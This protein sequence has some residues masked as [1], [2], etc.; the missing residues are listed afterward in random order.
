MLETLLQY[1]QSSPAALWGLF[2]IL[3]LCGLGVPVPEDII[4]ITAGIWATSVGFPWLVAALIMYA[5]VILGDSIIFLLGWKFGTRLLAL[6]GIKRIFP[7]AKQDRVRQMFARHGTKGLFIARFL[8]G[9]RAPFFC[10]AG[11]M[12]V[13]FLR[14]VSYDGLA[15]LVSVP[16]FVW[17]GHWLWSRFSEDIG[18]LHAALNETHFWTLVVTG[19]IALFVIAAVIVWRRSHRS[20]PA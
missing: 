12:H 9:L 8:P 15:A 7:A 2:F 13:P 5:G 19:A 14:F 1:I 6:E 18:A 16:L 4:L 20:K 10:T 17:L 3:L 11:A